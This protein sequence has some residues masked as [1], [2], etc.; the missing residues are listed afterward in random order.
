ME[1]VLALLAAVPFVLGFT[2]AAS[3][4]DRRDVE[5]AFADP[6]IV[7]SSGLVSRDGLFTTVNDSGD[8]GRVFVVDPAT[9]Q[10]VGETAFGEAEDVEAVAPAAGR[11]V[12]VGDIG[13]N[14]RVRDSVRLVRVPA[15]RSEQ[16]V[17]GTTYELVYADGSHDAE[18][19][20]VQPRTGRVYVV[21]KDFFGG[22]VYAAPKTLSTDRPN[23]LRPVGDALPIATDGAFFPDGRHVI[24]RDYS[25]A[26]V[27]TF[28]SLE[29]VGEVQLPEQP[30]GEGIAV[31]E[32]GAVFVSSEGAASEVLR[33]A[34][35]PRLEREVAAPEPAESGASPRPEKSPQLA[36]DAADAR[37]AAAPDDERDL[38]PWLAG[39]A[40]GLLLVLVLIR[41]LRP[42]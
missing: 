12:L 40:V 22:V 15:A 26:L 32:Q 13:D 30:Q 8:A 20:L 24:V 39:G 2:A 11:D 21:S 31:D 9:G 25:R 34:L 19:L 18:T 1:R 6:E 10:T 28:P 42:R 37:D 3:G 33:I 35:P 38:W 27:Y 36:P 16:T 29:Q 17:A 4:A 14:R 7:E 41:S 5:F 23:V